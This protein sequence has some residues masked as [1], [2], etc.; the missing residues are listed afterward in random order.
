MRLVILQWLAWLL[1]MR[2]S[3]F[4]RKSLGELSCDQMREDGLVAETGD[5]CSVKRRPM[6]PETC[7]SLWSMCRRQCLGRREKRR[8]AGRPAGAGGSNGGAVR[9][10]SQ[11]HAGLGQRPAVAAAGLSL[12][13]SLPLYEPLS[14]DPLIDGL[15]GLR[16]ASE[17]TSAAGFASRSSWRRLLAPGRPHPLRPASPADP[18]RLAAG[19][20]NSWRVLLDQLRFV[21]QRMRLQDELDTVL[22]EWKFAAMVL[23]RLCLILFTVF[24]VG[25]TSMFLLAA[26]MQDV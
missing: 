13:S 21:T 16:Y 18:A 8:S 24:T 9:R 26:N 17:A 4:L 23:D 1:R 11:P 12:L 15:Q 14:G 22:A 7:S 19:G 6:A 3:C 2:M 20:P 25:C 5:A 10:G